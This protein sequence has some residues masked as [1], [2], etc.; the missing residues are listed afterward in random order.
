MRQT[1]T[2]TPTRMW[3]V[4]ELV[5]RLL[6]SWRPRRKGKYQGA[7]VVS[8][9]GLVIWLAGRSDEAAIYF[10][11]AL[12]VAMHLG[13]RESW[14]VFQTARQRARVSFQD[15]CHRAR[16]ADLAVLRALERRI[17]SCRSPQRLRHTCHILE[18][19]NCPVAARAVRQRLADTA[20]QIRRSESTYVSNGQLGDIL[21][22]LLLQSEI[23]TSVTLTAELLRRLGAQQ[24]RDLGYLLTGLGLQ[25]NRYDLNEHSDTANTTHD[26]GTGLEDLAEFATGRDV[27][28]VGGGELTDEDLHLIKSS[29]LLVSIKTLIPERQPDL[30]FLDSRRAEEVLR[31]RAGPIAA[32]G[33]AVTLVIPESVQ[34]LARSRPTICFPQLRSL[35]LPMHLGQLAAVHLLQVGAKSLTLCGFDFYL[36]STFHRKHHVGATIQGAQRSQYEKSLDKRFRALVS[37]ELPLQFRLFQILLRKPAVNA[38][39][40]MNLLLALSLEEIDAQLRSRAEA[41]RFHGMSL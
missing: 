31:E 30:L 16:E 15:S 24:R 1:L 12:T 8:D 40:S 36:G 21:R 37:S 41:L 29:Q 20:Q 17:G 9:L 25:F 32:L 10:C 5:L 28:L 19:L 4:R 2:A 22:A 26:N 13:P 33:G 18:K 6:L 34:D 14:R 39:R 38:S 27:V 7:A 35:G 11:V 23:P 3:I